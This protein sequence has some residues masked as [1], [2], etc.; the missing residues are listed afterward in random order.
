MSPNHIDTIHNILHTTFNDHMFFLIHLS[1]MA[2]AVM[3]ENRT[4]RMTTLLHC[5]LYPLY[6]PPLIKTQLEYHID[7]KYLYLNVFII[8]AKLEHASHLLH[9]TSK[10]KL[11]I[12][13]YIDTKPFRN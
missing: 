13:K 1:L 9:I 5:R 11:Y 8:E 3:I 12:N 6:V 4:W 7:T 2:T 10:N